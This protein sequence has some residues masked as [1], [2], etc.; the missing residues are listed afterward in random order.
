MKKPALLVFVSVFL[1]VKSAHAFNP[2]PDPP[3]FG[4]FGITREQTLRLNVSDVPAANPQTPPDPCRVELTFVDSAGNQL[5]PAVQ[6]TI[7]PGASTHLDLNGADLFPIGDVAGLTRLEVRPVIRFLPNRAETGRRLLP[8]GPC[9]TTIELID[10]SNGKTVL[11]SG[12]QK[13]ET[14]HVTTPPDPNRVFG[15]TGIHVGQT[16][17]INV[18]NTSETPPDPCR[19]TIAFVDVNGDVV[20]RFTAVLK[21]GEA[22]FHDVS[23]QGGVDTTADVTPLT[24]VPLRGVVIV[25][26]LGSRATPPDPC[27]ATFEVFDSATGKTTAILSPQ[28]FDSN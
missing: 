5:V 12:P 28:R 17:R 7:A 26:S 16:A 27:H 20:S 10:H 24:Q 9:V 15:V 1:A 11:T 14:S 19:V 22:T 18:V 2:Q 23:P 4:M 25:Q 13:L 3:G 8:P 21:P 6:R